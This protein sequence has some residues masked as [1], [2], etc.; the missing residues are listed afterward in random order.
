VKD[1]KQISRFLTHVGEPTD[2]PDVL[3]TVALRSGGAK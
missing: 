2:T 3:L 1:P